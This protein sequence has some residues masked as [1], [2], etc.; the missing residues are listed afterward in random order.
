MCSVR[1]RF[2]WFT[3]LFAL[4]SLAFSSQSLK[5]HPLAR[6]AEGAFL[7]DPHRC[8]G[9]ITPT[10]SE[11][12]L[13]R[14]YGARNVRRADIDIGEGETERGTVLFPG[15][16]NAV[17]IL[18]GRSF[19]HPTCL[20]ISSPKTRWRTTERI[21]VG[22]TAEKIERINRFPFRLTGF[23]WDYEGRSMSW[24]KGKLAK[25]LVLDFLPTCKVSVADERAVT[26]DGIFS[27]AHPSMLRKKLTVVSIRIFWD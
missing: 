10:C 20:I 12:D 26:G 14:I 13:I 2:A 8:V 19:S 1:S 4:P 27:S 9:Q 22:T 17:E 18:W 21:T 7:I 16:P 25:E 24:G 23:S 11:K 5:D 6:E 15:T 3:V